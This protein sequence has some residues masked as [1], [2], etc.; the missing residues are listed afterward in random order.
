MNVQEPVRVSRSHTQRISA[1]VK[2]VFPLLCPVREAEWIEGWEP[3]VVL[4]TSGVAEDGCVF[5]THDDERKAVW[6]VTE[7]DPPGAIGFVKVESP[8]VTR[9]RIDLD[10]ADEGAT[11]ATVTYAFTALSAEGAPLVH[12]WTE[13]RYRGFMEDWESRLNHYLRT[14]TRRP[15]R[16]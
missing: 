9:I 16:R 15:D 3:E 8:V 10:P 13:D 1:P 4:T 6:T 11:A 12:S 2:E 14:G 7:Y 5:V